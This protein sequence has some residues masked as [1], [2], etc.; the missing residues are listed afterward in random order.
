LS[1]TVSSGRN[2]PSGLEQTS[3]AKQ[4]NHKNAKSVLARLNKETIRQEILHYWM[5]KQDKS[6][7]QR[8]SRCGCYT[9]YDAKRDYESRS[10][11]WY[12]L[13]RELSSNLAGE[14]G[15]VYIYKGALRALDW[16]DRFLQSQNDFAPSG[17]SSARQ[18]CETHHATEESHRRFFDAIVPVEKRTRLL[19]LWRWAGYSLGFWPTLI[20]G[21]QALYVTVEAVEDFVERHFL[22]QIMP[23]RTNQRCPELLKLLEACCEDEVHHK[24]DAARQLLG[25]DGDKK[26]MAWWAGPWSKIVK[27]GSA[28]A[29]AVARRI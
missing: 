21:N 20:G 2:D 10:S 24:E 16:R 18:F 25:D 11:A 22:E 29:A 26:Q 15:A 7:C 12:W 13:D 8:S 6:S 27:I 4:E 28:T 14:T 23:L 5:V 3:A 17:S 9:Y 1:S 19:P